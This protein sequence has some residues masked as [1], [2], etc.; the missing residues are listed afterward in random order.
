MEILKR[1]NS[2]VLILK[3]MV[4]KVMIIEKMNKMELMELRNYLYKEYGLKSIK[5]RLLEKKLGVKK[6]N[7][8]R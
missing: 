4:D 6:E 1:M 2:I 3:L 5:F 8:V 7:R